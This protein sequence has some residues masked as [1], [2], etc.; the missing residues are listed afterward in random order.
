MKKI[1][2]LTLGLAITLTAC[3]KKKTDDPSEALFKLDYTTQTVEQQK[4]SIEKEGVD[5]LNSLNSLPDE[6]FVKAISHLKELNPSINSNSLNS[7]YSVST[8]A[9]TKSIKGI[10]IASTTNSETGKL[11]DSYG[12]FTWNFA[13]KDWDEK[14]STTKLEISYPSDV[15]KTTNNAVFTMSAVASAIKTSNG[16]ELPASVSASLKV[17]NK[18]ELKLT[19]E[20]AYKANATPTKADINII[21]GSYSFITKIGNDGSKLTSSFSFLKGT[22]TLIALNTAVNGNLNFDVEDEETIVNNAN[23]TFEVMNIKLA[24]I[25]DIT[26]IQKAN[27]SINEAT[28]SLENVRQ[29]EIWNKHSKFVAINKKENL[30]M[31][32]VE[33]IPVGRNDCYTYWNGQTNVKE[34]E[35]E[36]YIDPRLIFKDNSKLSFDAFIDNGFSELRKELEEFTEKFD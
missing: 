5:F 24:G 15:S 25:V 20:Y 21:M 6:K 16:G 33:F 14:P 29:G 18:E 7:V 35:R 8:A 4:K 22:E 30:I 36:Y 27:S 2:F 31:A 10:F 12:I 1:L 19:S 32:R 3:K 23:A 9:K 11:S 17:D 28:D 34:C 26:A 13:K